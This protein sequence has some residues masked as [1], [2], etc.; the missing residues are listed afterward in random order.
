MFFMKSWRERFDQA[1]ADYNA[2]RVHQ[3]LDELAAECRKRCLEG[4]RGW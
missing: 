3:L 1:R 2:A 4:M